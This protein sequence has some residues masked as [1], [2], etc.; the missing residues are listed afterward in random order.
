MAAAIK[1]EPFPLACPD[2]WEKLQR[3]E[4]PIAKLEL[5]EPMANAAV[6]IFDNLCLP[7]VP[8]TPK[9][10]E[11]AGE[12]IRD[13]IRAWMGSVWGGVRS[14]IR[15][16]FLLVPKKNAK[17]TN[18]AAMMITALLMNK[19]PR[20]E[21]LLIGPTQAIADT[22]FSQAVGIIQADIEG[23]LQ[24]RFKIQEHIKTI[25][26]LTNGAK[27]RIKTF[28]NKVMTGVKP[29]GVLID[30]IHVIGKMAY[31]A[32]VIAQIRGGIIANPEGFLIF[33][34]TQS[35]EPPAGAFKS[36]LEY[37][38]NIRDGKIDGDMLPILF[39]MPFEIQ[40][41]ENQPWRDTK[42]WKFVLPNA[43]RSITIERLEGEFNKAVDKGDDALALWGSQHLNIEIGIAINATGWAG[44]RYWAGATDESL[45]LESLIERSE[46][47][48]IGIDGGGLD[49]LLGLAAV[50]RCE[51]TKDYLF[52][53]RAWAQSDVLE[54]RKQIASMLHDF[55]AD[56]DLVICQPDEPTRDIREVADAVE[57]VLLSGKLAEKHSVGLDP[58]GVAAIIDELA[59]RGITEDQMVAVFQ[60]YKLAGAVWGMERK[61]KD[62]TLWHAGSKLMNWCVGN[63]KAEQRG[64][65]VLITKQAAGKAKIDPLCAAFNAM[66]LMSRNPA[67]T[68]AVSIYATEPVMMV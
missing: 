67:A 1:P 5:N 15:E 25:E 45:S 27:L 46:V 24:K 29:V 47:I 21:F 65:A 33:I 52:W 59:G 3:F 31:A 54:K 11:A 55:E 62:G 26:D 14:I 19:R 61:L 66:H 13:V 22:A 4:T 18:G 16:I 28:D 34:T 39:E 17:T 12:W 44:A 42:F 63:A 32:K 2:W 8:G 48:V 43:G 68:S 35:D 53:M 9:L 49:D 38:R 7:D 56:G 23:V 64:N 41:D 50:G 51:I 60:G 30:E 58:V 10:G 40:A 36:E 6:G 20:G 37:A 57:Q